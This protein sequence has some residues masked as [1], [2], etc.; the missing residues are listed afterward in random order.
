VYFNLVEAGFCMANF[1]NVVMGLCAYVLT[2]NPAAVSSFD[3]HIA[4]RYA[5]TPTLI[6]AI[7]CICIIGTLS[8][9]TYA[10]HK[11]SKELEKY[12]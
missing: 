2:T 12:L 7:I 8:C 10:C 3:V 5:E 11:T 6:F 4:M 9:L 1:M